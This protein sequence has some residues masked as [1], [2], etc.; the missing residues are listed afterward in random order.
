MSP[1]PYSRQR[2]SEKLS[3][4]SDRVHP[5]FRPSE[6]AGQTLTRLLRYQSK[7]DYFY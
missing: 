5:E 7:G 3:V 1:L 6:I 2:V 4:H